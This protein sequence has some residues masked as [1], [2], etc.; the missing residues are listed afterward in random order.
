MSSEE[1]AVD[2]EHEVIRVTWACENG[3]E[4]F[5]I[6][7]LGT[8]VNFLAFTHGDECPRCKADGKE[9][10]VTVH[11]VERVDGGELEFHEH[12]DDWL[13]VERYAE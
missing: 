2:P 9:N 5:V 8:S 6:E 7:R 10:D 3:H 11:R 1:D 4:P 12:G 13:E